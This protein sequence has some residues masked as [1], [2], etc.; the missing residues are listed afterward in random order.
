M[1]DSNYPVVLN[2]PQKHG[3]QLLYPTIGEMLKAIDINRVVLSQS[4]LQ[5]LDSDLPSMR[6]E[7]RQELGEVVRCYAQKL[8]PGKAGGGEV[9]YDAVGDYSTP[10]ILTGH[11]CQFYHCGILIKYTLADFLA[12][13]IGGVVWNVAVD[14][15]LPKHSSLSVPIDS[16]GKL[17]VQHLPFCPDQLS[18]PV[19]LLPVPSVAEVGGIVAKLRSLTVPEKLKQPMA[20]LVETL[21]RIAGRGGNLGEFFVLLNRYLAEAINVSWCDLP[22]SEMSGS[23]AFTGF[24]LD[25]L[26]QRRRMSSCYNQA[27]GEFRAANRVRNQSQPLPDLTIDDNKIEMPFWILREQHSRSSLYVYESAGKIFLGDQDNA[28]LEI[29]AEAFEPNMQAVGQLRRLLKEGNMA[30][31]PKALMLTAFVR[32]FLADY[33]VHGIG[34]GRYDQVT[35]GFIRLFYG[36]EPPR[37]AVASATI[38]LFADCEPSLTAIDTERSRIQRLKRELLYNPQ[39]HIDDSVAGQADVAKLLEQRR[40]AVEDS[41]KLRSANGSAQQRRAAFEKIRDVNEQ[42][43][44]L[45]DKKRQELLAAEKRMTAQLEN[46]NVSA[47]REF[48]FGLF[49]RKELQQGLTIKHL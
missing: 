49:D 1:T 30:L 8:R 13:A 37:F 7:A 45:L 16:A 14:S 3:E 17:S 9:T 22:L 36:V 18:M 32:L 11:Q 26:L 44:G 5:I 28:L 12:R 33:F 38:H 34:G 41:R 6:R 31:R 2:T 23:S 43:S 40:Q 42:L 25:L 27:L 48:F 21:E 35:D 47:N 29:P 20:R 15:D 19:E 4:S 39:R 24:F 46:A 10:L